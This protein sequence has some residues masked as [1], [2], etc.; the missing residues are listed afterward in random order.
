MSSTQD[1][2]STVSVEIAE[3]NLGD[4]SCPGCGDPLRVIETRLPTSKFR[5]GPQTPEMGR[6]AVLIECSD[7]DCNVAWEVTSAVREDDE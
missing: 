1:A 5:L 3:A 6:R 2:D 7:E 4:E